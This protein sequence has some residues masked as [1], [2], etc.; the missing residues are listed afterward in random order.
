MKKYLIYLS[1]FFPFIA[2]AQQQLTLQNAIDTALRNNFDIRIA[3]NNAEIGRIQNTF[4]Y[5]GGLPVI[6]ANAGDNGSLSNI[7]QE[8]SDDTQIIE[9]GVLNNSM[10]AG[11]TAGMV[12]FN[13]FRVMATRERLSCLQQQSELQ[14]NQQIQNTMAA[15]MVKYYDIIRQDSYLKIIQHSLDV[16][17]KKSEI[18]SERDKVGMASAADILQAQMDVNASL[19]NL[20]LQQLVVDQAKADLCLLMGAKQY[21]PFIVNDSIVADPTLLMDSI[22]NFL[23]RNPQYLSAEQQIKIN[24]QIVKELS[25]QRYP[26]VKINTGYDYSYSRNYSGLTGMNQQYGPSA[27]LTLQIPIYNGNAYRI[28]KQS[29]VYNVDNATIERDR[30]LST[31]KS[32]AQKTYLSYSTTLKQI[33]SQRANYALAEKLVEVVLL[34]FQMNQATILEVKTAQTTFEEAAYLLVNLQYSA[35]AAEI[36]LKQMTY[37][38]SY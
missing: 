38:L 24:E 9:S 22:T 27:G 14:L 5:A 34:N 28:Q 10:D 6:S 13:G 25:A 19:Q 32:N 11:I 8:L 33:E 1:L 35:K 21:T 16:S 31:L 30:L 29:A 18:V 15:I 20:K 2:Q 36:E 26:T 37:Q 3:K 12:L 4:G 23:N 17:V 7:N